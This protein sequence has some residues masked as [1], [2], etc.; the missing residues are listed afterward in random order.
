MI[1]QISSQVKLLIT[2]F[3]PFKSQ[4]ENASLDVLNQFP[5]EIEGIQI[6]KLVLPVIYNNSRY[7]LFIDHY[8]PDILI[9]LGEAGGRKN[10][11]LER[12]AINLMDASIT[13][14]HGIIKQNEKILIE[15]P[16]E[17]LTNI[18]VDSVITTLKIQNY[19]VE[20]SESAGKYICNQAF[21]CSM[22]EVQT[23]KLPITIGFIH[24]PRLDHQV[25]LPNVPTL[26][27]EL[28]TKTVEA[29][30]NEILK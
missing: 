3:E 30:I 2:A 19:P 5:N 21:Y 7:A 13:D 22:H 29:L 17:Y 9:H 24:I 26:S 4:K 12:R 10:V 25:N 8:L 28:A 15:G 16:D 14:N 1:H 18:D 11:S 6:I 27:L 23:K 20:V